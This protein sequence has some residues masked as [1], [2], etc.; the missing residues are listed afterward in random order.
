MKARN[1]TQKRDPE[2]FDVM[3]RATTAWLRYYA[4]NHDYEAHPVRSNER[5]MKKCKRLAQKIQTEYE[6]MATEKGYEI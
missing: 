5:Y 2:F 3:S 1:V 6:Q 4:A